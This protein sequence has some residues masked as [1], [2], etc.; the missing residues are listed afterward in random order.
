MT[1]YALKII[2]RGDKLDMFSPSSLVK[3]HQILKL[4]LIGH[5][6]VLKLS[7]LCL[8]VL[9]V[10]I[11][12]LLPGVFV[13]M[14]TCYKLSRLSRLYIYYKDIDCEYIAELDAVACIK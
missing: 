1:S 12:L 4:I 3:K 14:A 10:V 8:D 9:G 7:L 11:S 5:S 6:Q 2:S 13:T